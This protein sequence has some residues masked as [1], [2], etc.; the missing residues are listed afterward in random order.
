AHTQAEAISM[1]AAILRI[2][3]YERVNLLAFEVDLQTTIIQIAPTFIEPILHG[4]K[5]TTIRLG[6]RNYRLGSAILHSESSDIDVRITGVRVATLSILTEDD[7][8]R[9]GFDTLEALRHRLC[10]FYP[11]IS[12]ESVITIV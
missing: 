8:I 1:S 7:A 12:D 5:K 10:D 11:D 2:A 9:D 4:N 6:H 3:E